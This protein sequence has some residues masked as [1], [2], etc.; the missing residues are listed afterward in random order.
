MAIQLSGVYPHPPGLHSGPQA[1]TQPQ[2]NFVRDF[3]LRS[4]FIWLG[5]PAP[6][7][8]SKWPSSSAQML[9]R[10][11]SLKTHCEGNSLK[12]PTVVSAARRVMFVNFNGIGNG[13]VAL[14]LLRS[15]DLAGGGWK[16]VHN[17]CGG[18][19]DPNFLIPFSLQGML[20]T[21]PTEWRRFLPVDHQSI[22]D[23][24]T[25]LEIDTVIN[26]RNEGPTR[27]LGYTLFKG[28][29]SH[30]F[31]FFD[32]DSHYALETPARTSIFAAQYRLI[33]DAGLNVEI[34]E[35]WMRRV[36]NP[37]IPR[38]LRIGIFPFASQTVKM[39]PISAW[40]ELVSLL[41]TTGR[42][43]LVVVSG[44]SAKDIEQ[45]DRLGQMLSEVHSEV[46]VVSG[47]S[48]LEFAKVIG[49]LSVLV[50]NDSSAVHIAAAQGVP[51]VGIYFATDF[52]IWGGLSPVFRA[53]QSEFGLRCPDQKPGAGNCTRFSGNCWAPCIDHVSPSRVAES[54]LELIADLNFHRSHSSEHSQTHHE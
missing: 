43:E 23:Y 17:A 31:K 46:E 39:W 10:L 26:L 33:C 38:R 6:P 11:L 48:I 53:V 47:L 50:S 13:V 16:Y 25:N 29:Y 54:V 32:L 44:A 22:L 41:R 19:D 28:K 49:G 18:F 4:N 14:G 37:Q 5:G 52:V 40:V 8:R 51:T 2:G 1:T 24:L 27:D 9:S 36:T 35:G 20:G 21:Y 45:A 34:R 42:F 3:G 12:D 7:R 30:V 15:I